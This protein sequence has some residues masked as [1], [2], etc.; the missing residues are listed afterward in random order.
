MA[1]YYRYGNQ[2]YE[3]EWHGSDAR[4]DPVEITL[5]AMSKE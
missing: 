5:Y 2:P 3:V 4:A 1:T